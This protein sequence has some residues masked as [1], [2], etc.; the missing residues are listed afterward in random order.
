MADYITTAALKSYLRISSATDDSLLADAISGACGTIDAITHRIF[1]PER[2]HIPNDDGS[3]DPFATRHYTP[4]SDRIGGDLVDNYTLRLNYDMVT[5]TSITNGDGSNVP[6]NAVVT[7]PADTRPF[8]FIQI[9]TA[10][11]YFWTYS[12]SPEQSISVYGKW[13]YSLSAPAAIKRAATRLAALLYRQR[14]GSPNT[15]D[16]IATAEGVYLASGKIPDS[17]MKM[18]SPYIRRS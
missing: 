16:A 18:I 8:G 7:I 14:D 4:L 11:G 15:D 10:S 2:I 12:G 13:G 1:S 6:L 5:L 9:K 17:V 3:S